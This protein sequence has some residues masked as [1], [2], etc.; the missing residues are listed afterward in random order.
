MTTKKC[1]ACGGEFPATVEHFYRRGEYLHGKCKI[2]YNKYQAERQSSPEA[3]AKRKSRL[4]SQ[5]EEINARQRDYYARN[6]EK[7]NDYYKEWDRAH[8]D[9]AL[10]RVHR[11][12]A[13]KV[14][15]GS[16]PYTRQD[17]LDR[18]GSD[19]HLC[20]EP[21]DLTVSGKPGRK[22]WERGLHLDHVVPLIDG[23]PDTLDNVRPSHGRCNMDKAHRRTRV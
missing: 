10:A 16:E 11:R 14:Q 18:Y 3:K 1:S 19:C 8:P 22:G 21:I 9:M 15:N 23:G 7:W 5:R 4:N 6:R 17:V 20:N 12:R 13:R 2:C